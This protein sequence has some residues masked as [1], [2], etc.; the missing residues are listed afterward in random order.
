MKKRFIV[1]MTLALSLFTLPVYAED[2]ELSMKAVSDTS[3]TVY[4]DCDHTLLKVAYSDGDDSHPTVWTS[5]NPDVISVKGSGTECSFTVHSSA[6]VTIT[7]VSEENPSV[8]IEFRLKAVDEEP[9]PQLYNERILLGDPKCGSIHDMTWDPD[10][11]EMFGD[12]D[13]L[14]GVYRTSFWC[15][16]YYSNEEI[17]KAVADTGVVRVLHIASPQ[18]IFSYNHLT[19]LTSLELRP[20]K[21]GKGVLTLGRKNQSIVLNVLFTDAKDSRQYFFEPVYWALENNITTGTSPLAF[22]PNQ[23]VSRAQMVTFL[24]RLA[25][26]PE[27]SGSLNF[28]DVEENRYYAKAIAW[29]AENHIT[30]GYAGTNKFGPDDHCTREQIVTFLYRYAGMPAAAKKA[31]FSDA[32]KGA[33]Y[34][35]ALSWALETGITRGLNDGT[36]RFGIGMNCTRAMCVTFLHRY[37]QNHPA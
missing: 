12:S 36:G 35:N 34:E 15:L 2:T 9:D 30:T 17:E 11:F 27:P 23:N 37:N 32:A 7:A 8:F 20:V 13:Y 1:L 14:L 24:W 29:A 16:P 31:E 33:Y 5:D 26:T 4:T 28:S 21:A 10:V 25:G 19:S 18:N 6:T 3:I 22:S